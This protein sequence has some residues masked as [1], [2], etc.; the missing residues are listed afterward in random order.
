MKATVQRH[1]LLAAAA[2]SALV[3]FAH[4][5]Y[6]QEA[7]RDSLKVQQA[8]T[9]HV[10]S[11]GK[12]KF[13]TRTFDLSHLP[14]YVPGPPV[15][16]LI[17]M[18]GQNYLADGFLAG[19]WE[20]EFRKY[21]PG[22]TFDY[23][24]Y[25]AFVAMSGLVTG[26][27]DLAPCRKFT[28]SDTEGFERIFN[29]HPT[30]ITFATGSLNVPGWNNCYCIF[31]HQ[32]NPL[33]QL[34]FKQLDGVFGA[35]RDGGWIGT[36]WHPEF[37]RGPEGNIRTWGQ[38][39]LTGEWAGR[40]IHPYGLNLRYNQSTIMSH[41]FLKGSDKWNEDLRTY[42]NFARSDG[43]M[44]LAATELMKDLAKDPH[45]IAYSGFHNLIPGT[46][47]L[48]IAREEG[49]PAVLP[50]LET[51]QDRTYPLAD[52]V[53]F[54]LAR[55]PGAPL[56]HK[57]KEYLRYVLSREGQDAVQRDGKYLPMTAKMVREQLR[58]LE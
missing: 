58:K 24:L 42:A 45:G 11:R 35:R 8:R 56:D 47:Y 6:G 50:S 38:L 23:H 44:A 21:H 2:L 4:P 9:D 49:G 1:T 48:A 43:T 34:N 39:G 7:V 14:P 3:W 10:V 27:A 32:T 22:V 26:Q 12:Q 5:A 51:L 46:K 53:Y 36:E 19:Y 30:E 55:A 16:G 25:T 28:F 17:R 57:L 40:A 15:T 18:W 20:E 41:M 13:Y 52:E 33:T 54:Y 29:F 37:A 31:V